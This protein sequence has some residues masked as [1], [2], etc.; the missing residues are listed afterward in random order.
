MTMNGAKLRARRTT[1][2]LSQSAA[3]SLASVSQ[4]NWS[5]HESGARPLTDT[6]LA[7]LSTAIGFRPSIAARVHRD[8]IKEICARHRARD[9]RLF[10]SVA[11]DTDTVESDLD[12][13]VVAEPGMTMFDIIAL[14]DELEILCG[15]RVDVVTTGAVRSGGRA[16][17]NLGA[18]AV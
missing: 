8:R 2:G 6:M 3:A 11:K 10:G 14:E 18:V 17:S 4:S 5:A 16:W 15:V 9:P 1:M 12:V 13:V 7:R